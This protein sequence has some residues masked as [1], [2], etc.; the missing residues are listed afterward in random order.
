[1]K[2]IT[3]KLRPLFILIFLFSLLVV[4]FPATPLQAQIDFKFQIPI[5]GLEGEMPVGKKEGDKMKSDL[6]AKYIEGIYNY[7]F[8]IAGILAAV[9][10]M[11]GGVIW[12]IS[13]G[14]KSTISK[15]KTMITSSLVGLVILLLS[16]FILDT[17][18]PELLKKR[19]ISID[20]MKEPEFSDYCCQCDLVESTT[21][22]NPTG[23][24]YTTQLPVNYCEQSNEEI[25]D[26]QCRETC[27]ERGG[28]GRVLKSSQVIKNAECNE[29]NICAAPPDA[30]LGT[31]IFGSIKDLSVACCVCGDYASR[32]NF[33]CNSS[34]NLSESACEKLC[35]DQKM[36]ML[37][38]KPK[39]TCAENIEITTPLE[40]RCVEINTLRFYQSYLDSSGW[41]F[42]P[43]IEKQINDASPELA[44]LLNCMSQ[45]LDPGVG[46]ISSISDSNNIGELQN[47]VG[48][49]YQNNDCVHSQ[50]SCHYGGGTFDKSHAVDLGDEE[51]YQAFIEAVKKCDTATKI[52]FEGD[53]IHISTNSCPKL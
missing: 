23:G 39:Q 27:E 37:I 24:S 11:A 8:M 3:L 42:D 15:A 21:S 31:P 29:K 1:M 49:N 30:A 13:A 50:N 19:D 17:I 7:S 28:A 34:P 35:K 40:Q 6:L 9:M 12:L 22:T 45:Y 26:E 4:V 25:S 52:L 20:M 16:Y 10:L 47:C 33:P 38:Y 46:R 53:H 5:P 41:T 14:N 32:T 48:D 18:N 44:Q 2:K 43:G 36:Q 51:N